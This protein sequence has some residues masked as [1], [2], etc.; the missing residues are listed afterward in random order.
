MP[1]GPEIQVVSSTETAFDGFEINS[2]CARGALRS[3]P[4]TK[5]AVNYYMA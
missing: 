5:I 4:A 2:E 1:H 3:V